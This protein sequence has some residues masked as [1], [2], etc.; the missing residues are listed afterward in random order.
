MNASWSFGGILVTA[1]PVGD[2]LHRNRHDTRTSIGV[3]HVR[4]V[5]GF[6]L[7]VFNNSI[8]CG[9]VTISTGSIA[10]WQSRNW[11][12]EKC[13]QFSNDERVQPLQR[14]RHETRLGPES[15]PA[16]KSRTVLLFLQL[17]CRLNCTLM[18]VCIPVW[19]APGDTQT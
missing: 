17:L 6:S 8:N 9:D 13:R 16:G 10:N 15:P 18:P 1:G 4:T 19:S 3:Q 7:S 14:G 5:K 11:K 2:T 12:S